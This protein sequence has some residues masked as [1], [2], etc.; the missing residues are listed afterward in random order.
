MTLNVIGRSA[1]GVDIDAFHPK[2]NDQNEFLGHVFGFQDHS[3]S[4]LSVLF[5]CKPF[6][7]DIN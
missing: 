1:F 2:D 7:L 5:A 3:Y 4:D 6:S